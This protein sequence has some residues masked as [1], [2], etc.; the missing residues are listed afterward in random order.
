MPDCPHL[1]AESL[2]VKAMGREVDFCP[3]RGPGARLLRTNTIPLLAA[4]INPPSGVGQE[5][6]HGPQ[7]ETNS[8][9]DGIGR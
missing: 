7:N 8:S 1:Q 9:W 3:F 5:Q 2:F 4:E 6:A